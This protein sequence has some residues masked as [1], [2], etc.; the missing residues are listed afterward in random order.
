MQFRPLSLLVAALAGHSISLVSAAPPAVSQNDP[1]A[2]S[3][4]LDLTPKNFE[5]TVGKDHWYVSS[6]LPPPRTLRI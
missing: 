5:E 3:K 6:P 4:I 2:D 1:V